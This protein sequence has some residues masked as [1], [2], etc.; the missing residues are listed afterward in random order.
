MHRIYDWNYKGMVFFEKFSVPVLIPSIVFF[1]AN[2][3]SCKDKQEYGYFLIQVDSISVT[4]A[5]F[6][7]NPFEIKFYGTVG[8]NGCYSF[9]RFNVKE[10]ERKPVTEAW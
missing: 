10:R 2:F 9:Y 8:N 5:A 7:N 1:I 6:L 4:D 3:I